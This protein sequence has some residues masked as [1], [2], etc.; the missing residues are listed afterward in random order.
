VASNIYEPDGGENSQRTSLSYPMPALCGDPDYRSLSQVLWRGRWFVLLSLLLGGAASYL[1]LHRLT[2]RYESTARILVG[3]PGVPANSNFPPSVGSDSENYVQTQAGLLLTRE[4][5]NTAMNDPN[6]QALPALALGNRLGKLVR[7][8]SAQVAKGTDLVKI[9][10]RSEHPEEPAALVNAVVQAYLRWHAANKQIGV[11]DLFKD[12]NAQLDN[13]LRELQA[14]RKDRLLFEQRHPEAVESFRGGVVSKT[15]ELLRQDLATARLE[16]I[17][18]DS[19]QKGLLRFEAEPTKFRQYVQNQRPA[20]AVVPE[21]AERTALATALYQAQLQIDEIL[22]GRT[23]RGMDTKVIKNKQAQIEKRIAE[24]DKEFVQ[25]HIALAQAA[26][27]E[28][29][30]R[31][32]EL[33]KMYEAELVKVQNLGGLDAEYAFITS[34]CTLMENL[35]S[36]L[37]TQISNLDLNARLEGPNTYVLER[38]MPATEPVWPRPMMVLALGLVAGLMMGFGLAFLWDWRDQSVRSADEVTALLGVPVLGAV[39]SMSRRRLMAR[40]QRLRFDATS[41]ESEAYRSIRTFLFLG[42]AREHAS[43]ILV[44]SPGP[45]EGKTTLV[46]NLGVAM[47]H[48]GQRTLILDA[49]LRKP[50]QHHIFGVDRHGPGLT[51]VLLGTATLEEAIQP[52]EVE[53]LDV[54]A[55][56]QRTSNPSELLNSPAFLHTLER[57]K[58][59]YAYVLVDSPPVGIVTDAQILANLCGL[60]LLVLRANKSSRLLTQRAGGALLTVNARVAGVIVN[61]VP[62]KD[63]KYSH[64]SVFSSYQSS[65]GGASGQTPRQELPP[66]AGHRPGKKVLTSPEG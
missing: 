47:A 55:S 31:E 63:T 33:T 43:T 34:E 16:A 24:L 5:V 60:T 62:K 29:A 28:A 18:Q 26:S 9:S 22:A 13:R 37:M 3:K 53:R 6:V 65:Y 35:C 41:R 56:G 32:Q 48:A 50:M 40:G 30:A 39:P 57:L 49:D 59:K 38:A 7:T 21:D 44:T 51:D 15:L 61:G 42:V 54:L 2:P 23:T 4:I 8:L 45:R 46:S 19:Y 14:K 27:E 25:R 10:A 12:L 66:N 58:N 11:A 64:Y 52:T 17:Q 1:C 20:N 36:G